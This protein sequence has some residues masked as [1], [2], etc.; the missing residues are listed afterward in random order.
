M[1]LCIQTHESGEEPILYV[2]I[3]L[4]SLVY[5][6]LVNASPCDTNPEGFCITKM[7]EDDNNVRAWFDRELDFDALLLGYDLMSS[8]HWTYYVC[9]G[10]W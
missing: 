8:K 10:E 5:V 4:I 6:T 3:S 7:D 1:S 2:I 9:S